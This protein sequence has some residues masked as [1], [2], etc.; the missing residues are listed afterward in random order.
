MLA[1]VDAAIALLDTQ[2]E[3]ADGAYGCVGFCMGGRLAYLTAAAR[4]EKIAAAVSFYGGGIAPD[5][6]RFFK[7]ILDRVPDVK[8]SLLLIYGADD[9]GIT[10]AEHA[11]LAQALSTAKKDYGIR[12]FPGAPHGFASR[13][14]ESYRPVQAEA[15]WLE[16]LQWLDAA[17]RPGRLGAGD[18]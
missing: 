4:K 7:P 9:D 12:V 16:T 6:P 2:L 18:A 17:L 8:G 15:A 13:D 1:D 3:V 5:Q 11:R 10:P 14:R